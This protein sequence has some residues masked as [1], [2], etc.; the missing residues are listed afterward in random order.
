[1]AMCKCGKCAACKKRMSSK[2]PAFLKGKY[3]EAKDKKK[4]AQMTK[5]LTPAQKREFEK[6]DKAHGDKKKPATMQ[7]D[8]KIDAKIIK[9][10]KAKKTGKK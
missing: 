7:Q 9:G 6:K 2:A 1:M 10:I 5:G 3:T 4:D 8:K